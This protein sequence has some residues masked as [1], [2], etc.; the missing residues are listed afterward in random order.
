MPRST[1][2]TQDSRRKALKALLRRRRPRT[3]QDLVRA[4]EEK[5]FAITQSSLSRDLMHLGARKVDGA[6][7]LVSGEEEEAEA[8]QAYPTLSELQPF[9]R[10]V[11]PA[12]PN[13]LVIATRPG[14]AQTVALALDSMAMPEVIGTIAGDDIVFV[15]TPQR[16]AQRSLERRF[17]H[18]FEGRD[19]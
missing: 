2:G 12:G 4:L 14:L 6:Y 15:A 11:R 10:S 19:S 3:Q 5:G 18:I 1:R 13:L 8:G 16:R 9:V 7:R 17:E